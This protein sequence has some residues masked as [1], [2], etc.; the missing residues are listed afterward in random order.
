MRDV[1]AQICASFSSSLRACLQN[2]SAAAR[3]SRAGGSFW[4]N[5]AS[6]LA[7]S[8]RASDCPL[9]RLGAEG[10]GEPGLSFPR[11]GGHRAS[12]QTT[13]AVRITG[14]SHGVRRL[15]EGGGACPDATVFASSLRR[16]APPAVEPLSKLF[17]CA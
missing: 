5:R 1:I 9:G 3:S 2:S 8:L 13:A 10:G 6:A 16:K 14:T 12:A 17:T 7:A 15:I 11:H 4:S